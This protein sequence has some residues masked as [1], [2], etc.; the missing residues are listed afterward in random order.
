MG[1]RTLRKNIQDQPGPAE[2]TTR[3]NPFEISFL[4]RRQFLIEKDQAGF[5]TRG[6]VEDLIEF[7]GTD[8]GFRVRVSASRT[9]AAN[10]YKPGRH[11]EFL[12]FCGGRIFLLDV[13]EQCLG[14]GF[15][16]FKE[17][18]INPGL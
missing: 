2:H 9:D 6:F 14:T 13:N 8:V 4:N 7:A 3:Q 15:R 1:S 11:R 18:S 5:Q 10:R 12:Q 17:Q 16:S